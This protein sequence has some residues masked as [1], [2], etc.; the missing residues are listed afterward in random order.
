MYRC[1][2]GRVLTRSRLKRQR[3]PGLQFPSVTRNLDLAPFSVV[4]GIRRTIAENILVS[5]LST[6]SRINVPPFRAATSLKM[7]VRESDDVPGMAIT[8]S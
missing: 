8:Y 2:G 5:K 3:D 6:D 7:S 1:D 4:E